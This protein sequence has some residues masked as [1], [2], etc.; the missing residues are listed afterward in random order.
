[1]LS[2]VEPYYKVFDRT[3]INM[4]IFVSNQVARLDVYITRQVNI[5]TKPDTDHI[6]SEVYV[7]TRSKPDNDHITSLCQDEVK[8]R[9]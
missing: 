4:E 5:S 6:T 1:M 8:T 9:Q 7:K 3:P 2:R